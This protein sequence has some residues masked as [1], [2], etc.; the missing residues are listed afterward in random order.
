M[1]IDEI[2]EL[3]RNALEDLKA[4]DI[5]A[6]GFIITDISNELGDWNVGKG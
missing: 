5:E 1:S 3:V 2:R 6:L 4:E